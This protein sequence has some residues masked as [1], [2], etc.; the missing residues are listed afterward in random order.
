MDFRRVKVAIFL[1]IGLVLMPTVLLSSIDG[2]VFRDYNLNGTQ[3]GL[4]PGVSGINVTAYDAAG[5]SISAVTDLNGSYHLATT[6]GSYRVEISGLPSYLHSGLAA[7][8]NGSALVSIVADAQ[9]HNVGL[10]SSGE[11]CQAD[12]EII[13]TRFT[14]DA[15]DGNGSAVN[16]L[17]QFP[18]SANGTD[19][20]AGLATYSDLGSVYGVAH[21]K[22]ANITLVS[23]YFKRH[24]DLGSGGPG[25]IYKLEHNNA[26]A[27]ST[28]AN[29]PGNT[30][31]RTAMPYDWTHDTQGYAS[32]GKVGVGDIEISDDES[33]LFAINMGQRTL[34]VYGIDISA[35]ISS[36]SIHSIP[37]PCPTLQDFRPMGLGFNDGKLYVGVTCTAESTVNINDPD[38]SYGGARYGDRS[39]LSA[40]IYSFDPALSTFAPTPVLDI[41]LTYS[42]G[43]SYDSN[44]SNT[45]PPG[46]CHQFTDKD[47]ATHPFTADWNPWQMDYDIVFNDKKPG[48]IGNQDA[49][50][51][52]QQPLLSD[53][54][55]D[56]DG[57]M[58]I[59]IKDINGDRTGH[60]NHSPDSTDFTSQNGNSYG[61]LLRACGNAELGWTLESNGTCGGSTTGGAGSGEGLGGGEYYW[62]D[63]GPGGNGNVNGGSSGHSETTMGG[64]L[65]IAGYP[66]IVTGVMDSQGGGVDNGLIWLRNDD[67]TVS[68]D[69]SSRPK[70]LLV[71]KDNGA[72][73]YG[74]A[75]GI[76]DMEALCDPAPIEIGNYIWNDIDRDGIQDPDEPALSGVVVELYEGSVL[77][78]TTTTDSS[79]TYYFGGLNS[80]GGVSLKYN[81]DYQIRVPL[82]TNAPLASLVVTVQDALSADQRDSDGDNGDLNANFS[83][84]AYTTGRAGES[85]HT[86]DFGFSAPALSVGSLIW[87]DSDGNGLQDATETPISGALVELLDGNGTVIDTKT[88]SMDGLYYFSNL[89]EG[90]YSIRVT[91]PSGYVPSPVQNISDNDDTATDSNIKIDNAD[92]SYTSGL[93]T[94]TNDSEPTAEDGLAGSDV[95]GTDD[96]NDNLTVDFGFYQPAS[97][98][99]RIWFDADADG[100]QDADELNV[101]EEINV[102][103][104]NG[105]TNALIST[106]TTTTGAY[107]F[108]DLIPGDYFV[109]FTL[110]VGYAVSPQ[111][112]GADGAVDSDTDATTLR[113]AVTT[114]TAGENDLTWDMGIVTM[115]TNVFDPPSAKKRVNAAG[116]PEI[117]WKMVWINDANAVAYNIV[118]EDPLSS[119]LT[120]VSGSLNCEPRGV[121]ATTRCEYDSVTHTVYWEGS[122]GSDIGGT[123]EDDSDN[124]VVITF[125][126]DVANAVLEVE[127]Q[128]IAFW[129][130]NGDGTVERN[131]STLSDDPIPLGDTDPTVAKKPVEVPTIG[132]IG[133]FV[134]ALLIALS[135]YALLYRRQRETLSFRD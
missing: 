130:H 1:T 54:E 118:V 44:I 61:D 9:I 7:D 66:D 23:A 69:G 56:Y 133:R 29:L 85:N 77:V 41:D 12:P 6:S 27:V 20:P 22:M 113:T 74:K 3:D 17:L 19:T 105:T 112:V 120:Y 25:T 127:N 90:N 91:P 26:N 122:I 68:L 52:Y 92:G 31:P 62:Y 86:L 50:L 57:S 73:F 35:N 125:R 79:G 43:C 87:N 119:D 108:T 104:Y 80:A 93:I 28:F 81:T 132:E 78:G 64:L 71:S 111:G 58:I 34:D 126:T 107:K 76:G 100:I 36:Y 48:N 21:L 38:D 131:E 98:G 14:K 101:T 49:Y 129:D 33:K 63:N 51:E 88:T 67:G 97:I 30:D 59:Q 24:S 121:S 75:S 102:T 96:N 47:G 135:A 106:I 95:N 99:N 116:W 5:V 70:R 55:F 39:Q 2:T 115:Y 18:Y 11:Y 82:S 89:D 83:T 123:S 94:L 110:P 128:A 46:S 72:F 8:S 65:Y 53:I 103:L 60:N 4:E 37:N 16:V 40:H 84:I 10:D 42:R 109:S 114:L 134:L 15:R 124:E 32:V 117:E 45:N 13:L